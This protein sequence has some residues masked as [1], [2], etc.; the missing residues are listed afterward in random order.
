MNGVFRRR[1]H[2]P[3]AFTLIEL[4]VVIL[5]IGILVALLLPA[6]MAAR[7]AARRFQCSHHLTQLIVAVHNYEDTWQAYPA[8]TQAKQGPVQNHAYGYHHSWITQLLPQLEQTNAFRQIDWTVGV[9]NS[10]NA[11]VRYLG[12]NVLG[13][14]SSYVHDGYS[15]YAAVHH[16]VEAPIDADNHGAFF[17]NRQLSYEDISD[18]LSETL[19]LGEQLTEPGDLGWMSGTRATLRNTGTPPNTTGF[20]NGTPSVVNAPLGSMASYPGY[21]LYDAYG[22]YS[23]EYGDGRLGGASVEGKAA[24]GQQEDAEVGDKPPPAPGPTLP[25]G[26]FGSMHVGGC[27]F[28]FG[29]GRVEFLSEFIAAAVYQQLAHRADGRILNEADD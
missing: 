15:S 2:P 6:I 14:P 26:G 28:A 10:K 24:V 20:V 17:L 25:V 27:Q 8:G 29:D 19:L 13:C 16:D 11:P 22:G 12:L 18:G 21:D 9:Y 1:G 3:P 5:V 7:E 4:L 23:V